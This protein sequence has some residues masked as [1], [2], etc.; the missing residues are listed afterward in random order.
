MKQIL[1]VRPD[2]QAASQ[3]ASQDQHKC[4]VGYCC[5]FKFSQSDLIE[6]QDDV[7]LCFAHM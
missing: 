1:R 3:A 2:S 6:D 5:F 4:H 7:I